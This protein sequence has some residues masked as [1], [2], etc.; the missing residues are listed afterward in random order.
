MDKIPIKNLFYILCYAWDL[1]DQR[2]RIKVDTEDC[3]TFPDLFARLLTMGVGI[4]LKRGLAR[5]Y[6]P[7]EEEIKGIKGKLE[8]SETVTRQSLVHGA[9]VCSYDDFTEDILINRILYSTMHAL[10]CMPEL[11]QENRRKLHRV[12]SL[13]PQVAMVDLSAE[14]FNSVAIT[15]DNRYY[16]LLINICRIIRER[17]LPSKAAEGHYSFVD[18][19]DEEMN[20]IFERFLFN[21][22]RCNMGGEYQEVKREN[23]VF[24]FEEIDQGSNDVLPEMVTDISLIN[25]KTKKKTIIDAKYYSSTLESKFVDSKGKVSRANVSQ[26][27]TYI[28]SAKG[29][30]SD[31]T[32]I[33]I[34]PQV[35]KPITASWKYHDHVV[36]VCTVNLNDDWQKIEARLTG[37]VTDK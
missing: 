12:Y 34:Y 19:D 9:T 11:A 3:K 33:L 6:V 7:C 35:S 8:V 23:L 10:M 22:Y 17:L 25:A 13:F 16:K 5:N 28:E 18:F 27:L 30:V 1:A 26:I 20:R 14:T 37:V 36:K 24:D 4:L 15:R 32:G 29:A 31:S 21:F 2:D